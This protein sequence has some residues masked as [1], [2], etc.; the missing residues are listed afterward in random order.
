MNLD[1]YIYVITKIIC[2]NKNME[3]QISCCATTH[4]YKHVLEI[5]MNS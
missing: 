3:R 5:A 2:L 4:A 1:E